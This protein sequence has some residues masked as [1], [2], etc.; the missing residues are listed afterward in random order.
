M[1]E[2]GTQTFV[3][4]NNHFQGKAPANAFMFKRMLGDE[5]ASVPEILRQAF[6]E[7]LEKFP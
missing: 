5:G 4:A 6:A 7:A 2:Q 3:I 1:A